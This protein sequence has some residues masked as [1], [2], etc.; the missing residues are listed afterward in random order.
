MAYNV[1]I[2]DLPARPA[3]VV[4]FTAHVSEMGDHLGKAFGAVAQHIEATSAGFAG[5]ALAYFEQ[6]GDQ[7]FN[8]RAGFPV[9]TPTGGA[10]EVEPFELPGGTVAITEHVGSYSKLSEA[11]E[12]LAQSARDAGYDV[13]TGGPSW[14]EYLTGPEVPPEQTRTLVYWPV[15]RRQ[16]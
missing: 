10:G 15:K 16:A 8:V 3:A 12:A 4:R 13:D 7:R 14:E 11:Y 9:T 2:K 1:E 6:L 5:P